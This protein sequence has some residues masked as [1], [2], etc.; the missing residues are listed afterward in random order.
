MAG[1]K[2][3]VTLATALATIAG[4]VAGVLAGEIPID[5]AGYAIAAALGA[6][7]LGRKLDRL[8]EVSAEVAK[9]SAEFEKA[10]RRS[11]E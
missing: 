9:V 11:G 5:Q 8:R 2:P 3:W 4:S 10:R 1:G 6:L 7:G